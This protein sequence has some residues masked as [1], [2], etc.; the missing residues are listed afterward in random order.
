MPAPRAATRCRCPGGTAGIVTVASG[1]WPGALA[2]QRPA[3]RHGRTLSVRRL[4]D[5]G[6]V[7]TLHRDRARESRATGPRR[8]PIGWP[9]DV[10]P[11]YRRRST[12]ARRPRMNASAVEPIRCPARAPSPSC[13]RVSP[14]ADELGRRFADGRARAAPGRRLGARRAAR[15]A[16]RRPRLRH[17]RPPGPDAGPGRRAGPTRSGRPGASSARSGP[18]RRGL[19][20][21]ITTYRAEAYDGVSRNPVVRY[22]TSLA[23]DLRRRD[24][25]V[26]AMAVSLPDH[27]VHRPV[28]RPGRPG[29]AGAPDAGHAGGVVRRRPAADAAGGP[30]RR[31]A[32]ASPV[33]R[34]ASRR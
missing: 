22:G 34:G 4:V 20:L 11:S 8:R 25:A 32:A 19:R 18:Q 28:R 21:E 30:V 33:A 3:T 17:R 13:M 29:R 26:N 14:V 7:G 15:P 5:P 9:P 27:D 31:A 23:D 16:R 12:S 1:S 10:R 6:A 24:F 2:R